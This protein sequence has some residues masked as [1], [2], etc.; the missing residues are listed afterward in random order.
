MLSPQVHG[1]SLLKALNQAMTTPCGMQ[2]IFNGLVIVWHDIIVVP[3]C[4]PFLFS[5]FLRCTE[6]KVHWSCHIVA[7]T[8]N[9]MVL[10]V[11]IVLTTYY[12]FL[13]TN[14]CLLVNASSLS[15]SNLCQLALI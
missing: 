10:W 7:Q 4:S 14:C 8:F 13:Y 3:L 12:Y 15:S 5:C 2:M 11:S 1:E 9:I 6:S